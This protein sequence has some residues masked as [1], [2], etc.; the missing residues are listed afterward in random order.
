LT[1]SGS[2]AYAEL[3]KSFHALS[4]SIGNSALTYQSYNVAATADKGWAA[5]YVPGS[6]L[7]TATTA[8]ANGV[9]PLI[10]THGNNFGIGLECQSFSNRNDTILS[11]IS[12]LN[13]QIYFTMGL[14]NGMTAGD[15]TKNY[16]YTIDFF[17]Q[18]D[19][20][21]IIRDGIMSARF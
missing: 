20:V 15:S 18:M 2:E 17:A 16:N 21:L 3:L 12:T 7:P 13:S 19:M 6:K 10:D 4:S 14:N 9:V 1:G 8:A 5:N 11:G